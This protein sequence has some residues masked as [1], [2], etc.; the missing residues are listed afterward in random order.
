MAPMNDV[1]SDILDTVDLRAALYFRTDYHPPFGV[2]VPAFERAA[3]FHLV[4]QGSCHVQ[5]E[6][7]TAA[8]VQTG[9][10]VLVPNGSPHL[11]TSSPEIDAVPLEDLLT[12]AGFSGSGPFVIGSGP[13]DESCQMVCGHFTFADGADHPMLRA[14][15]NLLHIPAADR[16]EKPMLN[17]IVQLIV[18][19]AFEDEPGAHAAVSRL[20]EILYIEL[21]RAGIA[22][23]PDIS[24][25]MSAVYDPKIGRALMLIHGDI[26]SHW[27]VDKLARAVGMS[28]SRFANQFRELVGSG[29]MNYVADWRLQRARQ[30]LSEPGASIKAIA[31]LVGYTS[32]AAFTRAFT[33]HFGRS[34]RQQR[35]AAQSDVALRLK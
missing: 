13:S 25:L 33:A 6:D 4:A 7:G 11:V 12:A 20:S 8:H 31:P 17:E 16:A 34:P 28:R 5:L 35:T 23:A 1:L 26:A 2:A 19:R 9:D 3:R 27:T 15:P 10:L 14:V 24:R 22:Q 21:M 30:L 32:S 29:P 18:R